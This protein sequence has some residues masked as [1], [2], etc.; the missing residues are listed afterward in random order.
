M[1]TLSNFSLEDLHFEKGG[2][3]TQLDASN[4]ENQPYLSRVITRT[5]GFRNVFDNIQIDH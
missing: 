1:S 2:Q 3:I 5:I 4:L